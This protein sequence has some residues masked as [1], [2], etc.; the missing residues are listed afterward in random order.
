MTNPKLREML[1]EMFAEEIGP[2]VGNPE[3]LAKHGPRLQKRRNQ[4]AEKWADAAL[5]VFTQYLQ[6]PDVVRK[7]SMRICRETHEPLN[8][9]KHMVMSMDISMNGELY[10]RL[11]AAALNSIGGE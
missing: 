4:T 11:A 1:E 7:A 10:E 3:W 8:S 9:S 6:E 2:P 5:A